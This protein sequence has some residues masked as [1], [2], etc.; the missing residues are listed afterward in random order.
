M[1]QSEVYSYQHLS[2]SEAAPIPLSSASAAEGSSL[3]TQL[4]PS[5]SGNTHYQQLADVEVH[6]SE[7]TVPRLELDNCAGVCCPVGTIYNHENASSFFSVLFSSLRFF[8][9]SYFF[10]CT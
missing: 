1:A 6:V 9:I 2:E 4:L 7:Q 10:Q 5:F 3:E 8:F